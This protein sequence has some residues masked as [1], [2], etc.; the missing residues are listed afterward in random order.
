MS[1]SVKVQAFRFMK[2]IEKRGATIE[3]VRAFTSFKDAHL[4]RTIIKEQLK[5]KAA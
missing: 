4:F 5:R 3:D 2:A 1:V